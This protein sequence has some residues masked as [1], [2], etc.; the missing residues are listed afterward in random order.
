MKHTLQ[1]F[2]TSTLTLLVCVPAASFALM[3]T[4]QRDAAKHSLQSAIND[5]VYSYSRQNTLHFLVNKGQKLRDQGEA[6]LKDLAMQKN[7]LRRRIIVQK[8]VIDYVSKQ[9]S[10]TLTGSGQVKLLINEEARRL[11]RMIRAEYFGQPLTTVGATRQVVLQAVLHAAAGSSAPVDTSAVQ[12][13]EMRFIGD[14]KAAERA[15]ESLPTLLSQRDLVLSQYRTAIGEL[16]TGEGMIVSSNAELSD[17]QRITADVHDEVLKIQGELA[18][19]DARL[20]SKAERAL[21]EKGLLDPSTIAQNQK[22]ASATPTFH[23][24]QYGPVSAGFMDSGYKQ[25]FGVPHLGM[26]I[27]VPQGSPVYAAADGVVFLVRDGGATGYS[28]VLIGHRGSYATL[29]GHVSQALV[30]AGQEVSAG[31]EIALSGGTP[32]VHGSGPMTTAA[33]VHFEVILA[34]KNINPRSVLP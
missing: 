18:R 19:I 17:I 29:Y 31:Q 5:A 3:A 33:H 14:L 7:D 9:Y 15:F 20:R 2:L 28:Y 26:D 4:D 8:G 13:A 23:W 6:H 24:P 11:T 30:A 32:R 34:G 27:V 21:I 12:Q 1:R 25:H 22:L 10:V 16:D